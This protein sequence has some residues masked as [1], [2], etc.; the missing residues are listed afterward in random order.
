LCYISCPSHPSWLD[1]SNHTWRR[2]QVMK[3][4]CI[5]QMYFIASQLAGV[6]VMYRTRQLQSPVSGAA[7][8]QHIPR[9]K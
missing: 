8:I 5:Q 9:V 1:H 6:W 4:H 3:P 2:V 7:Y